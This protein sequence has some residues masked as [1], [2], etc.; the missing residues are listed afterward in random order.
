MLQQLQ[1]AEYQV[2]NNGPKD[3]MK[4]GWFGIALHETKQR[5]SRRQYR[6]GCMLPLF[7]VDQ[8]TSQ[9]ILRQERGK[10]MLKQKERE[11]QRDWHWLFRKGRQT[12][13]FF[14]TQVHPEA[15]VCEANA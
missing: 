5:A 14:T 8:A 4:S 7:S 1:S 6:E 11:G 2:P 3:K 12:G 13:G 9:E 10:G 15:P